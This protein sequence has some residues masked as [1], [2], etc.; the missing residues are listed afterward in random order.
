MI[1]FWIFS[2]NWNQHRE[3]SEKWIFWIRMSYL[4]LLFSIFT[5][6]QAFSLLIWCLWYFIH[7]PTKEYG[8]ISTKW[9]KTEC[10]DSV[11][12]R[13]WSKNITHKYFTINYS[14]LFYM[15]SHFLLLSEIHAD[16]SLEGALGC[17]CLVIMLRN[18]GNEE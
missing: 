12:S 17:M 1:F 18:Y 8:F 10:T 5:V 14:H 3:D 7:C 6:L 16:R 15:R 9:S 11:I 13:L 2:Q 4:L